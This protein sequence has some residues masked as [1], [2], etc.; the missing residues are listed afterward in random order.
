M[1]RKAEVGGLGLFCELYC[2]LSFLRLVLR[3]GDCRNRVVVFETD[4]RLA[5]LNRVLREAD[6]GHVGFLLDFVCR[7][8]LCN[9]VFGH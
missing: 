3:D 6:L 7:V 9:L 2:V 8:C 4:L 1:H 5:R